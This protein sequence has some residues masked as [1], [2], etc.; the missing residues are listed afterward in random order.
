MRLID[1]GLGKSNA[2]DWK[3]RTGVVMGSVGYMRPSKRR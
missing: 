3:T 1:L 2:Q